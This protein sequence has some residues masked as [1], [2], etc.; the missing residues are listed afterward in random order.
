MPIKLNVTE[1]EIRFTSP[2]YK[3]PTVE[4]VADTPKDATPAS[5]VTLHENT[6]CA[7]MVKAH[8]IASTLWENNFDGLDITIEPPHNGIARVT[9]D[10]GRDEATSRAVLGRMAEIVAAEGQG[11]RPSLKSARRPQP[12]SP[13]H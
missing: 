9:V 6:R 7:I 10:A 5:L 8:A 13:A 12:P 4:I 1:T 3:V 2:P 11:P